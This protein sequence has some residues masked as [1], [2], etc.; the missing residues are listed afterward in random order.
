MGFYNRLIENGDKCTVYLYGEIGDVSGA[1]GSNEI[2]T[3][4]ADACDTGKPIE[5]R[6]NSNG[7]EVFAGIAIFNALRNCEGDVKIFVDGVAASMASVIALC[8]KHV[9]MSRYARLMIHRVSG[10]CFGNADD[11]QKCIV[12]L[13]EIEDTICEMYA[14]KLKMKPEEIRAKYFDGGEHWITAQ[15]ALKLGLINGIYDTD[16]VPTGTRPEDIYNTFNNRFKAEATDWD[17][18]KGDLKAFTARL[19][20]LLGLNPPYTEKA[21]YEAVRRL[22]RGKEQQDGK[23]QIENAVKMGWIE[24]GQRGMYEA[25][26]KSNKQAFNR[27]ISDRQRN[28]VIEVENLLNMAESSGKILNPERNLYKAIGREMGA[29]V[30]AELVAIR[31]GTRRVM[32][33]I[34]LNKENRKGWTLTDWRTYAP[35]ELRKNPKLYDELRK[36]EGGAPLTKSLEW[37]RRYNPDFLKENPEVYKQLVEQEYKNNKK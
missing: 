32:R 6:I 30:L 21:V 14:P 27:F 12:Q 3:D 8:G 5:V 28:E 37:Y 9:E 17:G 31:P 29:K 2:V 18:E 10:G 7:G 15:E 19:T 23:E 13:E 24:N 20:R 36:K 4:I 11:M 25:L 16:T 22:I 35:D 1:V 33:D 34:N 26:A